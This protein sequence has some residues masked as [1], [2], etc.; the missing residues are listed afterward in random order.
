MDR[1]HSILPASDFAKPDSVKA[2]TLCK[3]SHAIAVADGCPHTYVEYFT[4]GTEPTEAC[5]LHEPAP[6][7]EPII[8]YPNIFDMLESESESNSETDLSQLPDSGLPDNGQPGAGQPDNGLPG[9]GQPGTGLPDNGQ[10]GNGQSGTEQP[11][12]GNP[13]GNQE[14]LPD[15]TETE[16]GA[17]SK[18]ENPQYETN[19]LDDFMNRLMGGGLALP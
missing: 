10:T 14:T 11:S 8:I 1:V 12:P 9:A 2:V 7:T 17:D 16:S 13:P 5:G 18:W 15:K 6:E 3:D 19:S 4:E